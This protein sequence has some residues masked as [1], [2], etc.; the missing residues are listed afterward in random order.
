MA[1]THTNPSK[2]ISFEN[3]LFPTEERR[4]T[5]RDK[6]IIQ[7][8]EEDIPTAQEGFSAHEDPL[9]EMI[10]IIYASNIGEFSDEQEII[11]EL[12]HSLPYDL[13]IWVVTN[14]KVE[15]ER[16]YPFIDAILIY[17][18]EIQEERKVRDEAI[19]I[20][21]YLSNL[22][23]YKRIKRLQ[24]LPVKRRV[25]MSFSQ[26]PA[27]L[28]FD[29]PFEITEEQARLLS[30]LNEAQLYFLEI[31]SHHLSEAPS[32]KS[33]DPLLN[34]FLSLYE[35]D[36]EAPAKCL[37]LGCR[38]ALLSLP[39]VM[40]CPPPSICPP[41]YS[42]AS[43][44][45]QVSDSQFKYFKRIVEESPNWGGR[46]NIP[47]SGDDIPRTLTQHAGQIL[48]KFLLTI[49]LKEMERLYKIIMDIFPQFYNYDSYLLCSRENFSRMFLKGMPLYPTVLSVAKLYSD[50][51]SPNDPNKDRSSPIHLLYQE[52]TKLS[53]IDL[54]NTARSLLPAWSE[55]SGFNDENEA[56][57]YILDHHFQD[58]IRLSFFIKSIVN[59]IELRRLGNIIPSHSII[60]N[61]HTSDNHQLDAL[62]ISETEKEKEIG[63]VTRIGFIELKS[64][65][66]IH[67]HFFPP[68]NV[69]SQHK[70]QLIENFI[71]LVKAYP[72]AKISPVYIIY[73]TVGGIRI[74]KFND[75]EFVAEIKT[76]LSDDL[77]F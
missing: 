9:E 21:P 59:V 65:F 75:F 64:L 29:Y 6:R 7:V 39:P 22:E 66:S 54:H 25:Q 14:L 16:G 60:P 52:L 28:S 4:Q 62:L 30:E 74:I 55:D 10:S 46:D 45:N 26:T 12:I 42:L 1:K 72:Q 50:I 34:L 8:S 11:K 69:L 23:G 13:Y 32:Q 51:L 2:Q 37:I 24:E 3:A 70:K 5:R 38:G 47:R 67:G 68:K 63:E 56:L 61:S 15:E 33:N 18:S 76:L 48:E 73:L 44:G 57:E 20:D 77:P 41:Y 43:Y 58:M 36:V 53:G 19:E 17:I 31:Y 49:P 40:I 71:R 27:M 35:K